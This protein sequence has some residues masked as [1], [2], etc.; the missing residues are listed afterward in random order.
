VDTNATGNIS[1][2]RYM[3]TNPIP[4]GIVGFGGANPATDYEYFQLPMMATMKPTDTAIPFQWPSPQPYAQ[5]NNGPTIA[6]P[7]GTF[8]CSGGMNLQ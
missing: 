3:L 5:A 2:K 8:I 4:N 1:I 6:N 7:S